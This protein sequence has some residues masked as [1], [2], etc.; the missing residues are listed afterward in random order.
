M[1]KKKSLGSTPIGYDINRTSYTF[2]RDI[3]VSEP[4]ARSDQNGEGGGLKDRA[5]GQAV[6]EAK[7]AGKDKKQNSGQSDK[8][9]VSYYIEVELIDRLKQMAS[10]QDSYYSAVV[11][12][13]IQAWIEH[14]GF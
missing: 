7:L 10:E 14:H 11:S 4:K 3:G 5:T 1:G 2:I 13:A 6:S 12:R 9:I 8:K